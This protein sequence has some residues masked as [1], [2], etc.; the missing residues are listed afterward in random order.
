[1]TITQTT[2]N[3]QAFELP[4]HLAKFD[5]QPSPISSF[6]QTAMV[7]VG[8]GIELCVEIGGNP[9]NPPLLLI[10]GLGSQLIFWS[11]AFIQ[12]LIDN[13]FFVVRFD[14]RDIGLSTKIE[15][16]YR[17]PISH[18]KMMLRMQTGLPNHHLPVPYNLVDMAEDTA[19]L[20]DA[21][22]L[23]NVYV[24]GASM[25]G[26]IAQILAAKH[27]DKV[28]TLGLLFT[29]N[30]QPYLPPP[31][32]KQLKTLFKRPKS[33]EK[34]DV[35]AHSKWF[36]AT[37][38]SPDYLD[39]GEIERLATLRFERNHYPIGTIQQLRAILATGSLLAYD[40]KITQPTIII[41]GELDG[42]VPIGHGRAIAKAIARNKFIEIKGMGHDI[43]KA[44]LPQITTQ[45]IQHYAKNAS[46]HTTPMSHAKSLPHP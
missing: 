33:E 15:I 38:G 42:L 28:T 34:D 26:M 29:S 5:F 2:K 6:M 18:L 31:K 44:L 3:P 37:I 32:P 17:L 41:H 23:K 10:M 46:S 24:V 35:V 21:L 8:E 12:S 14:N 43:P 4:P 16:P 13:G 9:D 45:L 27:P 36:V 20:I 1:M 7:D 19:R 39:I 30:N 22:G 11:D 40:D 25:G